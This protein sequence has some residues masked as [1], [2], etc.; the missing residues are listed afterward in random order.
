MNGWMNNHHETEEHHTRER[1]K[2]NNR[3]LNDFPSHVSP[4]LRILPPLMLHDKFSIQGTF[5]LARCPNMIILSSRTFLRAP[6]LTSHQFLAKEPYNRDMEFTH[7]V[8]E[9]S[10]PPNQQFERLRQSESS[11]NSP[12]DNQSSSSSEGMGEPFTYMTDQSS[13]R[14][15]SGLVVSE[16]D[17][18]TQVRYLLGSALLKSSNCIFEGRTRESRYHCGH[19]ECEDDERV[20]EAHFGFYDLKA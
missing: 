13:M 15:R 20:L 14:R 8:L 19:G 4:R 3:F 18:A 17:R 10:H 2:S 9:Y 11:T 6:T 12:E 16:R 7:R 5:D 1:I